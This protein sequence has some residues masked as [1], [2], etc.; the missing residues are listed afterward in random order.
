MVQADNLRDLCLRIY[1]AP[2][3]H[4]TF[5]NSGL[6]IHADF[7]IT[8]EVLVCKGPET[9]CLTPRCEAMPGL[10]SSPSVMLNDNL[11]I[12]V[13]RASNFELLR[14]TSTCQCLRREH[15]M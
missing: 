1:V 14:Y 7:C 13:V 6:K 15:S 10:Q 8:E 12:L 2:I 11:V 4:P 5:Q 3:C 9:L